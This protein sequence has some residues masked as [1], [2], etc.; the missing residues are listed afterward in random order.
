MRYGCVC[1]E[2][3]EAITHILETG[4]CSHASFSTIK[5]KENHFSYLKNLI[6]I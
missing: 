3:K 6:A 4:H 1:K 2:R 5:E